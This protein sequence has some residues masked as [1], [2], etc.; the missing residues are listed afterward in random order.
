MA[1]W[2]E[3]GQDK[4]FGKAEVRMKHLHQ[5][6]RPTRLHHWSVDYSSEEVELRRTK[7]PEHE[8]D[9]DPHARPNH[10]I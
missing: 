4:S 1:L 2:E 5:R 3:M 10:L 6:I 9:E 7:T 8:G